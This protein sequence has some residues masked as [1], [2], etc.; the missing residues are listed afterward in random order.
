MANNTRPS[1]KDFHVSANTPAFTDKHLKTHLKFFNK[2][3]FPEYFTDFEHK[4]LTYVRTQ[5]LEEFDLERVKSDTFGNQ[6]YRPTKNSKFNA[7]D[8]SV[9]T[10]GVDLRK[11]PLQVVCSL[12]EKGNIVS[13]EF[14]FNGNTLNQVL[15]KKILQN[16][17]CAIYVANSNFS[18]PNLI[19]I[20]A[21]QNNLEKPF[22]A[23]DDTT[24]EHCLNEIIE[25]GGYPISKEPTHDEITEWTTKLKASMI[26]MGNGYDMDTAKANTII[27]DILKKAL[28]KTV[29]RTISDGTQAMEQL[30]N[31]GYKDTPTV[32]YGCIGAFKKGV[33][34]HFLTVYK[35][36]SD[37]D[38]KGTPEYFDF[39]RGRY[40]VV[41]HA[42]A[43][44][45]SNPINWFFEK[46]LKFWREWNEL[47]TFVNPTFP[48][49][50]DMRIIGAYQP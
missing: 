24:L 14:L 46:Y 32:K 33:Y 23:N 10:E 47:N 29:A 31:I 11:K 19:E 39:S 5:L 7:I 18:I 43:P 44:N 16:R 21:N 9:D 15:D 28:K 20:G 34:P 49:N 36:F 41:I 12:D 35:K 42:G 8:K 3:T 37:E 2:N 13:V 27:N 25:A 50:A 48:N 22:G 38:L 40:E 4:G 6:K 30:R 17:I 26:Y 45:M 1:A